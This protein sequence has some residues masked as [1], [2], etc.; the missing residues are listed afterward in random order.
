[1]DSAG[2]DVRKTL[3]VT[4]VEN[5]ALVIDRSWV[6]RRVDAIEFTENL[7]TRVRTSIDFTVPAETVP[8]RKRDSGENI[9]YLP[10]SILA[11]WPPLMRFD[12]RDERGVPIPLLTHGKNR[13]VDAAVLQAVAP[14]VPPSEAMADRTDLLKNVAVLDSTEA[15]GALNRLTAELRRYTDEHEPEMGGAVA[16]GWRNVKNVGGLL[17]R[18]SLLWARVTA[19]PEQ[20]QIVKYAYEMPVIPKLFIWRRILDALSWREVTSVYQVPALNW[21]GTYHLLIDAPPALQIHD[22]RL[23][24]RETIRQRP[25][26]PPPPGRPSVTEILQGLRRLARQA[27]T[28]ARSVVDELRV[29]VRSWAVRY[30]RAVADADVGEEA[31]PAPDHFIEPL[32]GQ[33][34]RWNMGQRVYLYVSRPAHRSAVARF[35]IRSEKRYVIAPL[36]TALVLAALMTIVS[37]AADAVVRNHADA[38]VTA[39]LVVPGLLGY[40]VVR[41]GEH[42]LVRRHLVGVRFLVIVAGAA[43]VVAAVTLLIQH[44]P[45]G[46]EI[47][48]YWLPL[49]VLAWLV[50]IV[51]TVSWILPAEGFRSIGP[52]PHETPP[53]SEDADEDPEV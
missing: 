33:P 46:A 40:L 16:E 4:A 1:M 2:Q 25:P 39:L 32:L 29:A 19:Y 26:Q 15:L 52:D 44:R 20:R 9:Y 30:V 53:T 14:D 50:A 34:Y 48:R 24:L 6:H 31:R 3:A 12:L 10:I 36:G 23:I 8:F 17:V 13:E 49:T 41:P 22:A 11:K 38:A 37:V 21:S 18:N 5:V 47:L 43:P 7:M 27:N 45:T 35:S 42:P 51:L 28:E